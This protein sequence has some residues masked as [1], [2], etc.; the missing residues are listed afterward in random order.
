MRPRFA[1]LVRIQQDRIDNTG[2]EPTRR[3]SDPSA[4]ATPV[5]ESGPRDLPGMLNSVRLAGPPGG[6][7]GGEFVSK[8]RRDPPRPPPRPRGPAPAMME[9]P[10]LAQRTAT[11]RS[12]PALAAVLL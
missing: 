3:R 12:I 4:I 6:D 9:E 2:L 1:E 5:F 10:L 7:N 11:P 8:Q